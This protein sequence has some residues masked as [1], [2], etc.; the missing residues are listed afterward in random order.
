MLKSQYWYKIAKSV[1]YTSVYT[2][3]IA[4]GLSTV[5]NL[6]QGDA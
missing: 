2:D 6:N 1:V 5:S 3:F 4:A